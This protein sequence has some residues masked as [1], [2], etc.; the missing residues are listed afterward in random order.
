MIDLPRSPAPSAI[1]WQYVDFGNMQAGA[2]GGTESRVNRL[3]NRWALT[4]T[5]PPM[6]NADA[7]QWSASLV[8]AIE[9]GARFRFTQPDFAP[10]APGAVLVNGA[11]QAG[12]SLVCDGATPGYAARKGQ[13]VSIE[14]G[15]RKYCYMLGATSRA[16]ASGNLTLSLVPRLRAEPADNDPVTIGAPEIEGLLMEAP[17]WAYDVD[18]VARGFTFT[19]KESR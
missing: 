6:S 16:D 10:G 8:A 5:M 4:V 14:T 3:G 12:N 9:S 17:S 18:R 7:R 13:F 1:S 15:S 11:S 19:I 2:L